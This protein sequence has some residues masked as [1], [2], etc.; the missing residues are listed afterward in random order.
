MIAAVMVI[1]GCAQH[2]SGP[3]LEMD[4]SPAWKADIYM[5]GRQDALDEIRNSPAFR[6]PQKALDGFD[7]RDPALPLDEPI[8]DDTW[9]AAYRRGNRTRRACGERLHAAQRV[10]YQMLDVVRDAK[11]D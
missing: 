9:W 2:D 8:T 3:R 5:Q 4:G 7:N 1:S 11:H 10:I 6:V